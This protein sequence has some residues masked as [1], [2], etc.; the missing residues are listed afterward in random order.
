MLLIE[1]EATMDDQVGADEDGTVTFPWAGRGTRGIR[2]RPG[3]HLKIEDVDIVEE[4][5]T[6]PTAKDDHLG[7]V[8]QVGGV[9]EAGSGCTTAFRALEPCHGKGVKGVQISEDRLVA[10]ASEDDDPGAS[11][12][13]RVAVPGRGRRSRY[14]RL[15]PP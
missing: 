11:Q 4:V 14:A 1:E 15:D 12:N 13:G 10:F 5:R 6:V 9:I 2:L 8:D 3:H 7:A